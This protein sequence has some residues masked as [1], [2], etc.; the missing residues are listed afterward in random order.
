MIEKTLGFV[1]EMLGGKFEICDDGFVICG[2]YDAK[3]KH[4]YDLIFDERG[5]F[6]YIKKC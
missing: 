6:E 3:F 2:I 5:A 1:A 4:K